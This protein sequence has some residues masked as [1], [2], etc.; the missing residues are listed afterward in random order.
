MKRFAR[1]VLTTA[2]FCC[3]LPCLSQTET[4]TIS[5]RVTDPQ[6]AVISGAEVQVQNVLTGWETVTRTNS[7]GLYVVT[8][9]QPGTYRVIVSNSGFKQIVKPG[10][11][12][13][14]QDNASLNFGMT[15]GSASETVTVEGG[16]PLVNTQDAAVSTVVDRTFVENM[17][18]NGRSFQDL[19]TLTPGVILT[20]P[21]STNSGGSGQFSVNGQ[22]TDSNAFTVD[23]VSA[24]V[25]TNPG[26]FSG[27]QVG[28]GLPG[29]TAMGGTQALV[30]VDAMQ[31]FRVQ[32]STFSAEYGRQP[33]AQISIVTR[34]GTNDFH[35]L[36]FDYLRNDVFDANDWFAK[37]N[38]QARPPERQNDF[39]GTFS[40]PLVIP[41]LYD[42]HN[43]TFFFFSYEGLRLR[44]PKFALT[45][46]PTVTLRQGVPSA[47]QPLVNS[48]PLPNG[49]DLGNGLAELSASYSD[50]SSLDAFSIRL[51]HAITQ[52]W[53]LFGR[54]SMTPS[55]NIIRDI[56]NLSDYSTTALKEQTITVGMTGSL[57]Q[58]TV[59]E[60]RFNYT[61]NIGRA[62][63]HSSNLFGAVPLSLSSILP[64]QY[65]A[66]TS[67][68][69]FVL[70]FSGITCSCVPELALLN[71]ILQDQRQINVVDNLSHSVGSHQL[72]FGIDYRRLTPFNAANVYRVDA[73]YL[74]QQ[75]L[76]NN[77][78]P[79]SLVSASLPSHPIFFNFSGYA[80]DTWKISS[81]LT[82]DYGVR[83]ELNP[84]PLDAR[85]SNSLAVTEVGGL[86]N[87]AL[88]PNG[89]RMWKTTYTNFAPRL[90]AAYMLSNKH[91]WEAVLREGFGLFYDTGN[92][93]ASSGQNGPY[94]FPFST[95]Q[96]AFGLSFPLTPA[97]VAPPTLPSLSNLTPP[98]GP[99][100]AFDPN[101]RLP[102]TL[103][104]NLSLQQ[105]LGT[106]QT[107]TISYVGAAGRRLLQQAEH[108]IAT[109]NPNFTVVGLTTNHA[110][111]D[112]D[113]LQVQFQRRLS[114]GLQAIA[115]YTWSHALDDDSS[116]NGTIIPVR[117]NASF[118]VRHSFSGAVTYD[119]PSPP[120]RTLLSAVFGHWS[121]DSRIDAR[122]ALP[123]DVIA[124]QVINPL[125]GALAAV[126]PDVVAGIPFYIDDPS[127][128]RGRVINSAAFTIPGPGQF[129]DLGRNI[130]RGLGAW[131]VNL[132]LRRQFRL[133]EKV[134]IQLRS[135][136]FNLLN[137]PNFGAI[138][139]DLS[140]ANFGQATNMLNRNLAGGTGLN[141]LYQFGGP[142][143]LQFALRLEF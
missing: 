59:N 104:W 41:S 19:L 44:L 97:Q 29:L 107:L 108:D 24:N 5:G 11:I 68:F 12:L 110:T 125:N 53:S 116:D 140:A 8:A 49:A 39:G 65:Y 62:S 85:N 50:P 54:Y 80:Q 43:R 66:D 7:S 115:S 102:Y 123:V 138:Q 99:L 114:H 27:A 109:I 51:D 132:A 76:L 130:L 81:R 103:Q 67:G 105:S 42:G 73:L 61:T 124:S 74:S 96:L 46:V 58:N 14:V 137:H 98:Y 30:S 122:T 127:A 71:G 134:S 23:G 9:L 38:E 1:L 88:A 69:S 142:R 21:I 78:S 77:S 33:G 2:L 139:T 17:P 32:S 131:Q 52:K 90:G 133:T 25:G 94:S 120:Q 87:M 118:D 95:S 93:Q 143:S 48:F 31:E 126:R 92:S 70:L 35:G 60:L 13:N 20:P 141:Q 22:R 72:K 37:H 83:W 28:G 129:G 112:Y 3:A 84:A 55:S 111:S 45:N 57:S 135:E 128:P 26:S 4:A 64:S 113:A 121:V 36:L 86:A 117:G 6:G 82:V 101:L 15:I 79:F 40:G 63:A 18:L 119:I 106:D 10:V 75:D 91:R 100:T 89:T 136:A 34:S 56:G 47:L 16:A